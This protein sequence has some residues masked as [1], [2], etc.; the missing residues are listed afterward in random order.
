[1]MAL[2]K[3]TRRKFDK[4]DTYTVKL[5]VVAKNRITGQKVLMASSRTVEVVDNYADHSQ[6][7]KDTLEKGEK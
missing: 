1:M 7:F 6:T 2:E 5:T 4:L 3:K